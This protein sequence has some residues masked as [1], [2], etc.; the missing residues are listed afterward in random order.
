MTK[1]SHCLEAGVTQPLPVLGTTTS[2]MSHVLAAL[3]LLLYSTRVGHLHLPGSATSPLHVLTSAFTDLG[4]LYWGRP[5]G[6]G[7]TGVGRPYWG[8]SAVLTSALLGS[9]L[10]GSEVTGVGYWGRKGFLLQASAEVGKGVCVARCL[11][12]IT[13]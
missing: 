6:V 11:A 7:L 2:S 5:T 1:G 9:A 8:R 12:H 10:L 13:M 4:G 3:R